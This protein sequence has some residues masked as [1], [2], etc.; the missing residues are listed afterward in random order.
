MNELCYEPLS[1]AHFE[2]MARL[3]SDPEVIRYTAVER[4]C[5]PAQSRL[6]MEALLEGQR[7]LPVPTIYLVRCK[8]EPCGVAGAPPLGKG[9]RRFGFFYQF[10]PGFWGRGIGGEAAA[11]LA[12][13]MRESYPRA[14]LAADAVERNAA[15][16][17]ILE[18]TGFLPCGVRQGD[19]ERNGLR[20]D[21]LSFRL[22]APEE[23]SGVQ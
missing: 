11:W 4:P 22:P 5:T 1:A 19:F 2:V 8:G 14:E 9:W 13:R 18:R 3:W 20:L 10:L 7:G 21:I 23:G 16:L 6:R 17:R 12:A 15:S